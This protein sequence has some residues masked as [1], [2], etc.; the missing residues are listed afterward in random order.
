MPKVRRWE[1]YQGVTKSLPFATASIVRATALSFNRLAV[2]VLGHDVRYA[3]LLYDRRRRKIGV[4]PLSE[5][6]LRARAVAKGTSG[7]RILSLR[8]FLTYFGIDHT[9]TKRYRVELD[10]EGVLVIDLRKPLGTSRE[11]KHGKQ[12][13]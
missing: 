1:T 12:R 4:R 8:G 7:T 6:K 9:K 2:E 13:I 11:A 3:E 10:K 5:G